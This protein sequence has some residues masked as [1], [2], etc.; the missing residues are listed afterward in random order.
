MS[1]Q[2]CKRVTIVDYVSGSV[3]YVFNLQRT[4]VIVKAKAG[5]EPK[6]CLGRVYNFKLGCFTKCLQLHGLYKNGRV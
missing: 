4:F 5:R 1:G 3:I 2:Y 6:S